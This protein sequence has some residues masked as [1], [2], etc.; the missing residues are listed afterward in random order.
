MALGDEYHASTDRNQKM[1]YVVKHAGSQDVRSIAGV[2]PWII[3]LGQKLQ[4]HYQQPIGA[5][6]P[7]VELILSGGVSIDIYK[8]QYRQLFGPN[9]N[10]Y[11]IYNASE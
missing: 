9:V 7:H 4:K 11:N 10:I 1:D 2:G 5:I 3:M 8:P 6:R